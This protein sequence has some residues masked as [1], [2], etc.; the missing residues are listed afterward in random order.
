[1]PYA[2]AR[3]QVSNGAIGL[4][5]LGLGLDPSAEI[6]PSIWQRF[7]D[8][9]AQRICDNSR[10][11]IQP[12]TIRCMLSS[13]D[14]RWGIVTNKPG[15]L[16]TPL[17]EALGISDSVQ[18]VVAGDTLAERKPHPAPLLHAAQLLDLLPHDCV[19]VGDAR[20]DIDAGVAAGMRT[21]VA[22][23]G[24]IPPSEDFQAWGADAC[25]AHPN[26][27]LGLLKSLA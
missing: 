24:Y 11:F 27:L 22:S 18:C 20:R 26:G 7:L 13:F 12:E 6:D 15:Y 23:Y 10:L 25:L 21:V 9:Y 19:Y 3:N 14:A 1:M 16:T 5:R 4:L 17:L 8:I 2:I